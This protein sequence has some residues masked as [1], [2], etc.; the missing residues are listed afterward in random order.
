MSNHCFFDM[1]KIEFKKY[2]NY[3]KKKPSWMKIFTT[4]LYLILFGFVLYFL[5]TLKS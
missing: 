2:Q 3:P 5:S 1:K 4:I